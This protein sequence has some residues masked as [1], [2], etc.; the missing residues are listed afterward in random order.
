MTLSLFLFPEEIDFAYLREGL[1]IP[2]VE[3]QLIRALRAACQDPGRGS[4][5][6][7]AVPLIRYRLTAKHNQTVSKQFTLFSIYLINTCFLN[8]SAVF[9]CA[10]CIVFISFIVHNLKLVY[11]VSIV[12][13]SH[14]IV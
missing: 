10:L 12:C 8:R 2:R 9:H 4:F 11:I 1:F 5:G 7:F 6:P 13:L 3:K 14:V